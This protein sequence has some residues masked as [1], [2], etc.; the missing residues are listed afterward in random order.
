[1][2]T[3]TAAF[4]FLA[5]YLKEEVD[6]DLSLCMVEHSPFGL[7]ISG[8]IKIYQY[9]VMKSNDVTMEKCPIDFYHRVAFTAQI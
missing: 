1:M 3:A 7:S 2:S 5:K 6:D 8:D 4:F 9:H